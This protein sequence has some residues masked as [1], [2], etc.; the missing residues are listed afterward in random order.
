[1]DQKEILQLI[2]DSISLLPDEKYRLMVAIRRWKVDEAKI[3]SLKD[4]FVQEKKDIGEKII[5]YKKKCIEIVMDFEIKKY[6]NINTK[7]IKSKIRKIQQKTKKIQTNIQEAKE[8]DQAE[9][10]LLQIE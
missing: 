9:K 4:I 6:E 1:M 8:K 7:K 2:S 3:A 10:V 5:A